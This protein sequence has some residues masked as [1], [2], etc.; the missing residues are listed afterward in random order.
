MAKIYLESLNPSIKPF[1]DSLG[2]DEIRVVTDTSEECIINQLKSSGV[3]ALKGEM[4]I[5]R[6]VNKRDII[7]LV[8]GKVVQEQKGDPYAVDTQSGKLYHVEFLRRS[9]NGLYPDILRI[10]PRNLDVRFA[11][12]AGEIVPL[13]KVEDFY[14]PLFNLGFQNLYILVEVPD[15]I[16]GH[17]ISIKADFYYLSKDGA[18]R[19]KINFDKILRYS[20][21]STER[22]SLR[23][24]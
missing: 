22:T 5:T 24:L 9:Y 3:S 23:F 20:S 2:D 8:S 21:K 6:N 4:T 16:G 13:C 18:E 19:L 15:D 12:E 17:K 10:Y 1:L 7:S 11:S 14:L